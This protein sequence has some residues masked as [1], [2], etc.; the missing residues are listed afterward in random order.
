M[1]VI[2]FTKTKLKIIKLIKTVFFQNLK[3]A[4]SRVLEKFSSYITTFYKKTFNS[5]HRTN[6]LTTRFSR[7]MFID[8]LKRV[9][10]YILSNVSQ[11]DLQSESAENTNHTKINLPAAVFMLPVFCFGFDRVLQSNY[12]LTATKTVMTVYLSDST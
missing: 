7:L 12:A 8:E 10:E 11:S 5:I 2:L 1:H 9:Q 6:I 3:N 4:N